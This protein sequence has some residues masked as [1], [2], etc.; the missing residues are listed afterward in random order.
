MRQPEHTYDEIIHIWA[1]DCKLEQLKVKAQIKA[2]S[3]FDPEAV[4]GVGAMGLGQFMPTTWEWAKEKGWIAKDADPFD[5]QDNI[6]AQCHYMRWLLDR[7]QNNYEFAWAAYNWGIGNVNKIFRW[8][9]WKT[10][11]PEETYTYIE[12][13]NR[14]HKEYM[15]V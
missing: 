14:Y 12:R 9:N 6:M 15:N 10:Y 2:E 5:P 3:L 8:A 7:F 1:D 4:S 11:L 13:I